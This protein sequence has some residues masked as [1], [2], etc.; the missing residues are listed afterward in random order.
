M[1]GIQEIILLIFLLVLVWFLIRELLRQQQQQI[2][3]YG[4]AQMKRICPKCDWQNDMDNKF[5]GD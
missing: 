1:I 4:E 2:V 5:C 3:V